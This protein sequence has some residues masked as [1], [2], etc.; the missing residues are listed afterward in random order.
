[1]SANP[2]RKQARQAEARRRFRRRACVHRPAADVD[3]VELAATITVSPGMVPH[4]LGVLATER[5]DLLATIPRARLQ[6][7]IR[8]HGV[9]RCPCCGDAMLLPGV[10]DD[11][12]DLLDDDANPPGPPGSPVG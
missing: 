5:P 3:P 1:M 2:D 7:L 4:M 10:M 11:Y 12:Q 6:Q 8:E 9:P